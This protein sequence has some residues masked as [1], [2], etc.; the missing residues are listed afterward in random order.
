MQLVYPPQ[1]GATT[2][3]VK[4]RGREARVPVTVP[5]F[6]KPVPIS[7]RN[8][9]VAALATGVLPTAAELKMFLES[10][11]SRKRARLIDELLERP[12]HADL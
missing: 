6:D 11:D 1:K 9:A 2:L 8:D 10:K 5:E 4:A 12:E 7:V 3:M